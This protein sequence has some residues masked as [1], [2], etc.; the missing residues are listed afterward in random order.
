MK[1]KYKFIL[2]II[3]ACLCSI[4]IYYLCEKPVAVDSTTLLITKQ[5]ELDKL[6]EMKEEYTFEN[7]Y[8]VVN[9]YEISPLTALVMFETKDSTTVTVTIKGKDNNTTYVNSF[10]PT[11]IHYLPI[12]GLYAGIENEV[13]IEMNGE[14]TVLK[15]KTEDL[16]E[17]MILPTKVE[18]NK[19]EVGNDL[20]F[21]TPSSKGYTVAYD[22]NGDV[23]WYLTTTAVW[24]VQR[25]DN[26][27]LILST[28]RLVNNPYYMT[29]LYEIDLLGKIYYEYSLEGGYHHDVYEM[30]NG[31]LLVA[32]DNFDGDTVEDYIV[33]I[34][35]TTGEIVKT[36]DL[37]EILDM[38]DGKNDDYSTEYDWFHN[39]S[40]WY[41]ENTNSIT[42][43]GRHQDAIIN[44][45]Y[46]TSNLNWII[47]D[48]TNW[49]EEMH[50]YFFT[51]TDDNFVWQYAQHAAMI[52]PEGYVFV[53][54]NGNNKS[55]KEENSID[56]ND[57]YSRGVMFKIDTK[58]MTIETVWEY[59]KNE[60][61]SFY[62]P[63]ISDV[64]Y[65]DK[66]HYIVHSGGHSTVESGVNNSPAGLGAKVL[67]MN[68]IT[69]EL[70][71]NKQI[72]RM[73]LPTNTY[74][75]EKLS[76]YSNDTYTTD[77]GVRLG[78]LGKTKE[79]GK[80]GTLLFD[81]DGDEVTETIEKYNLKF[82][83]EEDRLAVT[84]TFKKSD[85]IDIILDNVFDK[86]SYKMIIST[87]PYTALCIDLNTTS[88]S[89]E[90]LTV[91]KYINDEGFNGKY[92]LYMRI[93][94]T[95]YDFDLFVDYR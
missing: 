62:S 43:S 77:K 91:T 12:Y 78:S 31:N 70:K 36:F 68:S 85:N 94:G 22:V 79:D 18:A 25:L 83:K 37:T 84:G 86:K 29:G 8:V 35:R 3:V 21:V 50:K 5:N 9:P 10:K 16:P 17:N 34:D 52:T 23:R 54:D 75:V 48:K 80:K 63:Y 58:N 47:G 93:N 88:N 69:V 87:K 49:K 41:D 95:V 42:L 45:D 90:E 39:N 13:I 24:D 53:F 73:E 66:N 65:L 2:L 57:N 26:G 30:P 60:G 71:D 56:A 59:G 20:Y 67:S 15:I 32:S 64:D 19:N 38:E 7:P 28:N 76:L 33:E 40:V 11:N 46:T 27:H 61:S 4:A 82:V 89:D 92:Y 44:I 81:K 14:Q 51:P 72:F 1:T 55:K 6:Y 74:R